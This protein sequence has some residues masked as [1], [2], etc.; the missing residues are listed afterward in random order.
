VGGRSSSVGGGNSRR[1]SGCRLFILLRAAARCWSN[2]LCPCL[3]SLLPTSQHPVASKEASTA[4]ACAKGCKRRAHQIGA[5]CAELDLK[6]PHL[7]VL[8]FL[9]AAQLC[10]TLAALRIREPDAIFHWVASHLS[11]TFEPAGLRERKKKDEKEGVNMPKSCGIY[12][13]V[14]AL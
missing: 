10:S 2:I 11:R 4:A 13:S 5:I 9:D 1:S 6:F 12:M 14:D 8:F 3:R 7:A